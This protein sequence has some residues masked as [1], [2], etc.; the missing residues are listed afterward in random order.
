MEFQTFTAH[1]KSAYGL[2]LWLIPVVY[3][4]VRFT[5]TL[6]YARAHLFIYSYVM[7]TIDKC[8]RIC[9]KWNAG[10]FNLWFT[11]FGEKAAPYRLRIDRLIT[12][13]LF[14]FLSYRESSFP[15]AAGKYR[16]HM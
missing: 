9:V 3:A 14:W 15:S 13:N 7:Y 11:D 16:Y 1:E 8:A 10:C 2:Y 4:C 12:C 5:H 6:I